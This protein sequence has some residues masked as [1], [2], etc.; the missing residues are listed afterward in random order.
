MVMVHIKLSAVNVALG[1]L[2]VQCMLGSDD[3]N[4]VI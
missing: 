2:L 3:L 1:K 4:P